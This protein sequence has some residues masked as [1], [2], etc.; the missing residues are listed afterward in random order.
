[1]TY[2]QAVCIY[3]PSA[4][5]GVEQSQLESIREVLSGFA[6]D[7]R[8]APTDLPGHATELAKQAAVEGCDLLAVYSGDGTVNEVVQGLA[9]RPSTALLALP[10]GTAN[11]L[12]NEVGLPKDPL[13]A[14]SLLPQLNAKPVRLGRAVIQSNGLSRY[15]LL[16]CSAGLDAVIADRVS[17]ALKHSVGQAA[18]WLAGAQFFFQRFP[19]VRVSAASNGKANPPCGLVVVAKSRLYGGRLVL[20][21]GA[22][23]LADHFVMAEYPG[24]NRLAYSSYLTA[25]RCHLISKCPGVRL[26][27]R[28]DLVL[29][30]ADGKPVQV[31]VDGEVI[32]EAP[33]RITLS[34]AK[35]TVLVPNSYVAS[36]RSQERLKG[37]TVAEE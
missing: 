14:A 34:D 25:A 28:A 21:P 33:V 22:N 32:G 12:V 26:E 19:Q 24:S 30:P 4:G 13:K 1:M 17:T 3:N 15:F 11:V 29:E 9:G 35:C 6:G 31:Q 5:R 18:Y 23:L 10:G 36:Y 8:L 7:V 20:A 16:M 27:A 2:R 37:S